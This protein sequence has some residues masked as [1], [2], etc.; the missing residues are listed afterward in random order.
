MLGGLYPDGQLGM[1]RMEDIAAQRRASAGLG[2]AQTQNIGLASL[3]RG[4]E[5]SLDAS[6]KPR[7]DSIKDELQNE[8]DEWLKDTI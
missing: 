3:Y 6:I 5:I 4:H 2:Q 7:C 1:H 8:V